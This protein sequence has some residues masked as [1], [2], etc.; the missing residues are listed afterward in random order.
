MSARLRRGGFV[1][2]Y[3]EGFVKGSGLDFEI[4]FAA[5]TGAQ[6]DGPQSPRGRGWN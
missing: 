2:D 1:K 4:A 3:V 6:P 5:T